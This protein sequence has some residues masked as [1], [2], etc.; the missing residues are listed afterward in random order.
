MM[1]SYSGAALFIESGA[2]AMEAETTVRQSRATISLIKLASARYR[3]V[4]VL[5]IIANLRFWFA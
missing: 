2:I 3:K 5:I 1:M 4:T